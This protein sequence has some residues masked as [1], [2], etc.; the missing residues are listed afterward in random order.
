MIIPIRK[1]EV[2][3]EEWEEAEASHKLKAVSS[4]FIIRL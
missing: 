4:I 3:T 1:I 2:K